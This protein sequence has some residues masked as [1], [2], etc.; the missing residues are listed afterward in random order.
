M[1]DLDIISIVKKQR[2]ST[3]AD[4]SMSMSKQ[5]TEISSATVGH[6]LDEQGLY[7]LKPLLKPLLSD[8]NRL[9][10][11]KWAKS[12]RNTDW[13]KVVFTDEITIFQFG[14]SKQV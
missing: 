10:R 1:E 2:T 9:N 7:K 13:S 11:L 5:G 8:I 14:K 6:R 4:I 12:N 3:L